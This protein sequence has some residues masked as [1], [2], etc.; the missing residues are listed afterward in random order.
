MANL[1]KKNQKIFKNKIFTKIVTYSHKKILSPTIN[2]VKQE[3]LL[4]IELKVLNFIKCMQ[5]IKF[6]QEI[7]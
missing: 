4:L 7:H 2:F 3:N 6:N 5:L 1:I